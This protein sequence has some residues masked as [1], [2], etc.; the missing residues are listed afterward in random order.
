[1][2]P[3]EGLEKIAEFVKNH[4]TEIARQYPS[5]E[6]DPVYRWD[7]TLSTMPVQTSY[8]PRF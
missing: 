8:D 4:L 6:N 2:I 3:K 1:M 7:H 5:P